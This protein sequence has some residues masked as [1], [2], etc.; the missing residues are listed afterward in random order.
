MQQKDGRG[1][2]LPNALAKYEKK[3]K[4]IHHKNY[5]LKPPSQKRPRRFT[6]PMP[7]CSSLWARTCEAASPQTPLVASCEAGLSSGSPPEQK[8]KQYLAPTY[9]SVTSFKICLS[10]SETLAHEA[11]LYASTM[12]GM[13]TWRDAAVER[14]ASARSAT[15]TAAEGTLGPVTFVLGQVELTKPGSIDSMRKSRKST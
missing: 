1:T 11:A 13:A 8:L 15:A 12:A 10:P 6:L 5:G 4:P 14:D 3:M 7:R 9:R 2:A